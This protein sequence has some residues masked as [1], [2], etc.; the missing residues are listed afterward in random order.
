MLTQLTHVE[1]LWSIFQVINN[2][3]DDYTLQ[4]REA[5]YGVDQG[6]R[7]ILGKAKVQVSRLAGALHAVSLAATVFEQLI[8]DD[9]L[10]E[11]DEKSKPVFDLLKRVVRNFK[12]KHRWLIVSEETAK[13][14]VSLM[15]YF[16]NQKKIYKNRKLHIRN[17]AL[18]KWC[19]LPIFFI[20]YFSLGFIS[21]TH[22]IHTFIFFSFIECNYTHPE[23]HWAFEN[24]AVLEKQ[25]EEDAFQSFL[26]RI[27]C[28]LLMVYEYN[29][30]SSSTVFF[31]FILYKIKY[32]T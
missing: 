2:V 3:F 7:S 1:K 20:R 15:N 18:E 11:Y 29:N 28:W 17:Q 4:I 22:V 32:S 27:I 31:V 19:S 24:K 12:E 30:R 8:E 26:L 13:A 21:A 9:A 10:P 6:L 16:I 23:I 14:A 5:S 25:K